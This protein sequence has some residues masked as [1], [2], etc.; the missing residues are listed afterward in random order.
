MSRQYHKGGIDFCLNG[1]LIF[2]G[3]R[4]DDKAFHPK[5]SRSKA[6]QT[7]TERL[8][9]NHD[10]AF[11]VEIDGPLREGKGVVPLRRLI[12]AEAKFPVCQA[13]LRI[14]ELRIS[15]RVIA[16]YSKLVLADV[17]E[18]TAPTGNRRIRTAKDDEMLAVELD[19]RAAEA[20]FAVVVIAIDLEVVEV[21]AAWAGHGDRSIRSYERK[22]AARNLL[23]VRDGQRL[24]HRVAA[25]DD[26]R[27]PS[28]GG[29][30]ARIDGR[31]NAFGKGHLLQFG[32]VDLCRSGVLPDLDLPAVAGSLGIEQD[33]AGIE[34]AE[35]QAVGS[36]GA[37]V[38]DQLAG[39]VRDA[40]DLEGIVVGGAD[41]LL[42]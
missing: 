13:V 29:E 9:D 33:R 12:G 28:V 38:Q 21:L 42:D 2:K 31:G 24:V 22:R 16:S 23:D 40:G 4:S 14:E 32:E 39:P 10:V 15:D 34:R 26:L 37:A 8:T 3:G 6:C 19:D 41:D 1:E 30:N 18:R 11:A 5:D 17:R 20:A 7:A 27:E 25:I 36:A 35:I